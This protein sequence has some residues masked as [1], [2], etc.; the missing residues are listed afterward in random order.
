MSR[1]AI[2]TGN[3]TSVEVPPDPVDRAADTAMM[4]ADKPS[5]IAFERKVPGSNTTI[6]LPQQTVRLEIIQNIRGSTEM[7]DAWVDVSKQ[8][9]VVVGMKDHPT[10]PDTDVQRADLFLH[11]GFMWEVIEVINNVPGR[12]LANAV[13][14]P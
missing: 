7:Q 5:V 10:I 13:V 9:V 3:F 4:I 14:Q 11:L 2:W 1:A 6:T 8:Y 12:L